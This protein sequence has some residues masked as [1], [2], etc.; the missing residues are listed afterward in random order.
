MAQTAED[1]DRIVH[2]TPVGR[3]RE[4]DRRDA[5]LIRFERS[6]LLHPRAGEALILAASPI[7]GRTRARRPI[8]GRGL[9]GFARLLFG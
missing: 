1:R 5:S 2:A 3:S 4:A 8:R 6:A 9:R 7:P